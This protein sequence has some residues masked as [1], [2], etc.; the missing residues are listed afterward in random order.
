MTGCKLYIVKVYIVV[1]YCHTKRRL[2][3]DRLTGLQNLQRSLELERKVMVISTYFCK[4]Y[5]YKD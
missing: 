4:I 1:I 3:I 2:H 5:I